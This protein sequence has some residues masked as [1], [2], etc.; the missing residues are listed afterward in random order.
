ML[1]QVHHRS[2]KWDLLTTGTALQWRAHLATATLLCLLCLVGCKKAEGE[3]CSESADCETKLSCIEWDEL[4]E[5]VLGKCEGEKCCVGGARQGKVEEA[6]LQRETRISQ[7]NR[8]IDRINEAQTTI[9]S[10]SVV[11]PTAL[12][13]LAGTLEGVAK[14]VKAVKF[15][16]KKLVGFRND[17]AE[18]CVELS[19]TANKAAKAFE[20][21]DPVKAAAAARKLSS[22]GARELKLVTK[23]NTYCKGG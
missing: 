5:E 8:L 9:K 2:R 4:H 15:A 14:K 16:D 3:S 7:C 21:K 20:S 19:G 6:K 13:T 22:F 23:I 18:M 10:I 11:D 1:R 12:V 17:Y